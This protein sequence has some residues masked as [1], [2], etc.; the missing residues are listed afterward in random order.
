M[1]FWSEVDWY[2]LE[3]KLNGRISFVMFTVIKKM[4]LY[5]RVSQKNTVWIGMAKNSNIINYIDFFNY[6]ILTQLRFKNWQN[7]EKVVI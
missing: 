2:S 3:I 7:T 6:V 1:S 5:A 4:Y